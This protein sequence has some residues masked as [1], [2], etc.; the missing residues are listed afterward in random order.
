MEENVGAIL[1]LVC[2]DCKVHNFANLFP[3]IYLPS[4]HDFEGSTT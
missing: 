3:Q 2:K 1:G 4:K